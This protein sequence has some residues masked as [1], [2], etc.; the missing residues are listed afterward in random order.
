[1]VF[2]PER[3]SIYPKGKSWSLQFPGR[4]YLEALFQLTPK[5]RSVPLPLLV[6]SALKSRQKSYFPWALDLFFK[7]EEEDNVIHWEWWLSLSCYE[8]SISFNVSNIP[9]LWEKWRSVTVNSDIHGFGKILLFFLHL[10][11]FREF[12]VKMQIQFPEKSSP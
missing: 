9:S 11:L 6:L 10:S 3:E 4:N 5:V 7:Y 1:M 8:H 12:W 2:S